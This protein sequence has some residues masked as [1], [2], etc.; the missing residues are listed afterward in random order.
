MK[1]ILK[2][3][4][5]RG[6][7]FYNSGH[8]HFVN[9]ESIFAGKT[10]E[11]IIYNEEKQRWCEDNGNEADYEF[12][13]DGT[14]YLNLDHEY[15]TTTC[16]FENDLNQKQIYAIIEAIN[17]KSTHLNEL[18]RIIKEHYPEYE[19]EIKKSVL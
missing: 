10:I 7:R 1:K 17:E 12:N 14:G 15:D 6:G 8:V 5:G 2:F 13:D 18:I 11:N 9:F 19:D 3:W 16:V 4:T